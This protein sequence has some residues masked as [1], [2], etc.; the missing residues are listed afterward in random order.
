M[1]I[2]EVFIAHF[3]IKETQFHPDTGVC[4]PCYYVL[5]LWPQEN[6]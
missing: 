1:N 5:L 4:Y 3:G 6:Q 2:A